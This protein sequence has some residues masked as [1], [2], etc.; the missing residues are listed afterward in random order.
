MSLVVPSVDEVRGMG[1]AALEAALRDLDVV[2]REAESAAA[3]L[4]ARAEEARV[5]KADGHRTPRAL[6]MAACNWSY[7]DAGVLVQCAH[8]LQVLPAAYGLGVSQLHALAGLVANPRVRH[9]L[10]DAEGE[11]VGRAQRMDFPEYA[12]WLT[13][14]EGTVDV[15]GSEA[16]A[17]RV[18]E[19]RDAKV[20]SVGAATFIDGK[21]GTAQGAQVQE[22]F[23]AFCE[24]EFLA[25]WEQGVAIH[26]EA[27]NRSLLARTDAQRRFDAMHA[28][29]LA[30]GAAKRGKG[31][32]GGGPVVNL[33]WDYAS[34]EH[35]LV[36]AAGGSPA[37]LDPNVAHFCRTT[38]GVPVDPR[39]AL[40]AALVGQVRRVVVD[41]AGVIVNM[42]RKQ[43][44][45]TGAVREAIL[46]LQIRCMWTGCRARPREVDH[47]I[48][49]ARGGLTD[50]A[51]AGPGCGHH[52]RWKA[53]GYTTTRDAEGVFRHY[54]P[55]G[56][57]I[58]WR[59]GGITRLLTPVAA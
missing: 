4:L 43:R 19:G 46:A 3:L 34:F 39:D 10:A 45:F 6:G 52:N 23:D 25:D 54:R 49:W 5:F 41:S 18:H 50:A 53:R 38:A 32:E 27:M 37:P 58:G 16:A 17:D 29:F 36:L 11:L 12:V 24:A 57:E 13:E 33:V 15:A 44:L 47:L 8:V 55:D 56:T 21:G 9:A 40:I 28:V 31:G 20:R 42:G 1:P 48:P 35:Q 26:G 7:A 2:R 59:A 30:A 51:N 22:V 14:W